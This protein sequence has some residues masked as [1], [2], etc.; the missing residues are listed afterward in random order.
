MGSS[1]V[2]NIVVL[3][4]NSSLDA[5][6][7]AVPRSACFGKAMEMGSAG[8][9]S[10]LSVRDSVRLCKT[11]P[12]VLLKLELSRQR[13]AAC[14]VCLGHCSTQVPLFRAW[15]SPCFRLSQLQSLFLPA[16]LPQGLARMWSLKEDKEEQAQIATDVGLGLDVLAGVW[17]GNHGKVKAVTEHDGKFS[18]VVKFES[19][20]LLSWGVL[21]VGL[22][23]AVLFPP[24]ATGHVVLSSW[25]QASLN[26]DGLEV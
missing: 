3:S 19:E 25:S 5:H 12:D 18:F 1:E 24:A 11:E 2:T 21:E 9:L 7:S 4:S 13:A 16:L 23:R 20:G 10:G 15:S 8:L 26:W 17:K 6:L 22:F 14:T